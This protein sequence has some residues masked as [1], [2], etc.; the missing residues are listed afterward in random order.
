MTDDS[1]N[2]TRQARVRMGDI[3]AEK[4]H[5]DAEGSCTAFMEADCSEATASYIFRTPSTPGV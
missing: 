2:E 1:G 4:A 5:V 3:G